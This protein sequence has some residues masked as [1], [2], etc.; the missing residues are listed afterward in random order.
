M[1]LIHW[2]FGWH[3]ST[4]SLCSFYFTYNYGSFGVLSFGVARCDPVR[5]IQLARALYCHL[6]MCIY[7]TNQFNWTHFRCLPII[8]MTTLSKW[9]YSVNFIWIYKY[10]RIVV[11]V[12]IFLNK[13]RKPSEAIAIFFFLWNWT[14]IYRS[15]DVFDLKILKFMQFI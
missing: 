9:L 10:E 3:V 1:N 11:C 7:Y 2:S 5:P 8:I 15:I 6:F 12:I 4:I 14:E 13:Y